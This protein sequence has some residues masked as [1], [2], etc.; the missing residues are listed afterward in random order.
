MQRDT[1]YINRVYDAGK[2]SFGFHCGAKRFRITSSIVKSK[3]AQRARWR[4][5]FQYSRAEKLKT[6][7]RPAWNELRLLRGASDKVFVL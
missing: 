4:D 2:M 5:V 7:Y 3:W 1:F 6:H